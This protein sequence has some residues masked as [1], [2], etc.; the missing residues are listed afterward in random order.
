M[1]RPYFISS[2]VRT[3][4]HP[5]HDKTIIK[6]PKVKTIIDNITLF[7]IMSPVA[8]KVSAIPLHITQQRMIISSTNLINF[9]ILCK[10]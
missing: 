8:K 9:L 5:A 2:L 7:L 6:K 1:L 10:A 3:D 4:S